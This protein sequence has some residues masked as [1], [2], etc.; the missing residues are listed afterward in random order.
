LKTRAIE[1]GRYSDAEI[2]I[3]IVPD[4][5]KFLEFVKKEAQALVDAGERDEWE[6]GYQVDKRLR[7]QGFEEIE[8]LNLE[9]CYTIPPEQ[10][11]IDAMK[12]SNE[13]LD[14]QVEGA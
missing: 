8:P 5:F 7:E 4:E 2:A 10:W 11:Q 13:I 1:F 6:I 3:F 9:S 12:V 14:Q